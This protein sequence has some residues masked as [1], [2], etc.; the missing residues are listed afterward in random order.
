MFL[1]RQTSFWFDMSQ[2]QDMYEIWLYHQNETTNF[3]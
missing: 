2:A 3:Y 1:F